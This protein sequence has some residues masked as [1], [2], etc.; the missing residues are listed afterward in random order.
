MSSFKDNFT[1]EDKASEGLSY[2]DSAFYFFFCSIL[3]IAIVVDLI[4][5]IKSCWKKPILIDKPN[6]PKKKIVLCE[7]EVFWKLYKAKKEQAQQ[8]FASTTNFAKLIVLGVLIVSFLY[9]YQ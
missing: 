1:W 4:L 5:I 6:D 8:K 2:D 7:T 9:C 3:I